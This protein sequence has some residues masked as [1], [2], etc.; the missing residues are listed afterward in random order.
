MKDMQTVSNNFNFSICIYLMIFL[1]RETLQ[2]NNLFRIIYFF[3]ISFV[4]LTKHSFLC[5]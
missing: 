3:F 5:I 4:H 1:F 2:V